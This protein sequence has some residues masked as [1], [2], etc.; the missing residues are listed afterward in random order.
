ME[1]D[2]EDLAENVGSFGNYCHMLN[3]YINSNIYWSKLSVNASGIDLSK[4]DQFFNPDLS[5]KT[6]N[7]VIQRAGYG[8]VKDEFFD[9]L[10]P[11]VMK[12][13]IRGAYYYLNSYVGW[14][15]QLEKFLDIVRGHDFHFFA[16]DFEEYGG[17]VLSTQFARDTYQWI[18]SV[19]ILTEKPVLLY[20][21][22]GHYDNYISK[23]GD[24]WDAVDYWHAQWTGATELTLPIGRASWKVWQY[25]GEG[26]GGIGSEYGLGSARCDINRFNGTVNDMRQWLGID[27]SI[28]EIPNGDEMVNKTYDNGVIRKEWREFESDIQAVI[29]PPS[30]IKII[31]WKYYNTCTQVGDVE[32]DFVYNSTP[33]NT[34]NCYPREGLRIN[35]NNIVSYLTYDPFVA[36]YNNLTYI[37]HSEKDYNKYNTV[38]Q[39]WRYV[40]EKGVKGK[41]SPS[42]DLINPCRLIGRL[43]NGSHVVV[44]VKGRDINNR[45]INLHEAT[46]IGLDLGCDYMVHGDSGESTNSY[47]RVNGEKDFFSGVS[48]PDEVAVVGVVTFNEPLV[49]DVTTPP[50]TNTD[51][52]PVKSTVQLDDGS[53]WEATEF[54]RIV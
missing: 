13:P 22:K 33:F 44:S 27:D 24:N 30:A 32:G 45:G 50:P 9:K 38:S 19:A 7:F 12:I 34:S 49:D 51:V 36:F 46:K 3:S 18:R 21:R 35:G 15:E 5:I 11:G 4:Y 10:L 25:G 28:P 39:F 6:I 54:I 1:G 52:I 2:N 41:T 43:P 48:T 37:G 53:V 42:W 16:A 20:T 47:L 14:R 26:W 31:T 40:I 17:N 8:L 29:I 23:S